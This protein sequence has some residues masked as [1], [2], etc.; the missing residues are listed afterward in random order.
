MASVGEMLR[1]ERERQGL[2]LARIAFETRIKQQFLEA[3]EQDDFDP[4]P[5]RFFVRAFAIQYAERLGVH[6]PE[7]DAALE[8]QL[9]PVEIFSASQG[10]QTGL[11][12]WSGKEFS[13]DPLPE[14]TASALTARKLTASLIML[15]AVIIACGA[16][17][18]LWQRSQLS[19]TSASG[20]QAGEPAQAQTPSPVSARRTVAPPAA[21][22][23]PLP[24][25]P[26]PFAPGRIFLT[27]VAKEETWVRITADGKVVAE[28]LL[29]R[30]ESRVASANER[31]RILLGNAGGVDIQFNGTAIG[32]VGPR[33]QVRT[34]EF[35][36]EK[37]TVI[38]PQKQP[39]PAPSTEGTSTP[40]GN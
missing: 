12:D 31:A 37:F 9:A 16:I 3:L 4:L 2:D 6:T 35:T 8:R 15:V 18:W 10:Q 1:R 21:I 34:V 40:V 23:P 20:S 33:G 5:G 36:P 7:L 30:G 27:V 26:E 13:V 17:F 29:A 25:L 28:R 11:P 32:Q 38:E 24:S 22:Q 14:G 19:S 39:N